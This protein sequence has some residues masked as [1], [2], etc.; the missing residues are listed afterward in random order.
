MPFFG[1]GGLAGGDSSA[2]SID[3]RLV[4]ALKQQFPQLAQTQQAPDP[5]A[6]YQWPGINFGSGQTSNNFSNLSPFEG[7]KGFGSESIT[8]GLALGNY[9]KSSSQGSSTP[10]GST[11]QPF[12]LGTLSL[13]TLALPQQV[14]ATQGGFGADLGGPSA[15]SGEGSGGGV[16]VSAGDVLDAGQ[17]LKT[18]FGSPPE[19]PSGN[20]ESQALQAQRAGERVD[21]SS[22]TGSPGGI[23]Q[24]F[25]SAGPGLQGEVGR[26]LAP[27]SDIFNPNQISGTEPT[28][29][30]GAGSGGGGDVSSG[31]PQ[32]DLLGGTLGTLQG[33][34]NLYGGVQSG[35]IGQVFSGG[36]GTLA[37]LGAM[38]PDTASG[39]SNA[40]G[41]GGSGLSM[42]TGAL[43]GA[44]GAYGLYQ[45]I[46][47]GD[48]L[49]SVMS[50]VNLY[51]SIAPLVNAALDTS[52]PTL[53]SLASQALTAVAPELASSLGIGTGAGVGA[54]V[55]ATAGTTAATAGAEAAGSAAAG[56]A[57]LPVGMVAGPYI[58]AKIIQGIQDMTEGKTG[59]YHLQNRVNRIYGQL[60]GELSQL[61]SVPGIVGKL[62]PNSSPED[63]A[64]ILSELN[65]IQQGYSDQGWEDY[66]KQGSTSVQN[67]FGGKDFTAQLPDVQQALVAMSPY[68][69]QLNIGRLRGQDLLANAGWTPEQVTQ[70]TGK[71]VTPTDFALLANS[72]YSNSTGNPF[73]LD[74][75]THPEF[76][77][78]TPTLNAALRP[79]MLQTNQRLGTNNLQEQISTGLLGGG[80]VSGLTPQQLQV[81]G[82]SPT[83]QYT[84]QD[85]ANYFNQGGSG[86]GQTSNGPLGTTSNSVMG[87]LNALQP[88]H[89]E[90]QIADLLKGYGGVNP[91][92]TSMGFGQGLQAPPVD[93]VTQ[94]LMDYQKQIA[95]LGGGLP[96]IAS[97]IEGQ[98]TAGMDPALVAALGPNATPGFT[99]TPEGGGGAV[100]L[101]ALLKQLGLA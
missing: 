99:S 68:L 40:L 26:G 56:A 36:A 6:G 9:G 79:D 46:E 28:I 76:Q 91:M 41:L 35:N 47:Q 101:Q 31:A 48:P 8:A 16:T 3:P 77:G 62:L 23:P 32:G 61:S 86:V 54:G 33:L 19:Q 50:A 7:A 59:A 73:T 10:A 1:P 80:D 57:A 71:Y 27:P 100:D 64:K 4:E 13:P 12:S 34:Y 98:A 2:S 24:F 78:Y 49:Q 22:A 20:P 67:T 60:P 5:L 66:A 44:A 58:V 93:P 74:P 70:Q 15:G 25:P 29:L 53:S 18:L 85:L 81:L 82:L 45:G 42:A 97:G 88:G 87:Q 51:G 83:A 89:L 55:G 95:A 30:A 65:T 72:M 75:S 17:N 43:G 92:W 38:A 52:L 63:T 11:A 37:G 69:T 90:Q 14:A 94:Q 84:N 21:Y 39:L 96:Q